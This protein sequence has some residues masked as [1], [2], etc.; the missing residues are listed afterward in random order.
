MDLLVLLKI[1]LLSDLFF[2][3]LQCHSFKYFDY[4][5][6]IFPYPIFWTKEKKSFVEILVCTNFLEELNK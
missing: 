5:W 4:T 2:H 3:L 1:W 6:E